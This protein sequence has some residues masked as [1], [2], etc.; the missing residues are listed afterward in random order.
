MRVL[1]SEDAQRFVG[2]ASFEALSGA[3]VL[4]GEFDEDP[5]RGAWPGEA[6]LAH[7]PIGHLE[8]A[9][10]AELYVIAPASA[11]TLARLASERPTT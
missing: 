8:L 5:A 11:S 2:A 9:D 3:P 1:Q 6:E 4:V 7:Q 10:R